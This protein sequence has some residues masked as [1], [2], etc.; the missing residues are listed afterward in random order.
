MS[1]GSNKLIWIIAFL[2]LPSISFSQNKE[3]KEK[4]VSN[5]IKQM[6]LEEKVG[7][8]WQI[9]G[10]FATGPGGENMGGLKAIA[11]GKVGS[12]LNVSGVNNVRKFQE[13]ALQSRLKIPLVFGMDV[14]HGFRTGFPIPLAEASSF[15]LEIIEQG[16]RWTATAAAAAGLNWTFA[17]MVDVS[18]DARWG[19]V[20]EGAGEDAFYGAGVAVAKVNGLQGDD[21][22]KDNTIMA[23]VKHFAGYGA[24]IAGKDYNNVDMSM[25]HFANFYMAPY[26]AAAEAGA[27]TFM[28]AFNDFDNIPSTANSFLLKKLLREKWGFKGFV[29]SDWGSVEELINHRV[30]E[31]KK[32]AAYK[33]LTAGLDMEMVSSCYNEN[34]VSLVNEK[35]ISIKEIDDAVR[36]ILNKKFELGLFEDPFR[37]CDDEREKKTVESPESREIARRLAERSIV[38]LKKDGKTL[39]FS[40]DVRN[41]ALIGPLA[42]SKQDMKGAWSNANTENIITLYDAMQQRGVT[43]NYA[44]GYDLEKNTIK[45]FD[46]TLSMVDKS[47]VIVIAMGERA[48]ESGEMRSKT[49]I[50]IPAA[51]QKLVSRLVK[52][53]KP[54]VVLMMSGRPVIFNQ[55]KKE[56]PNIL[57]TWWLGSEAGPAICNVLWGDY[58]PSGK[59]A[60][61]FP[62]NVGQIPIY[63]QYKSTGRPY[64]GDWSAKYID[65][66]VE[67][68][69]P[70]G[71]GL[72]YTDFEYSNIRLVPSHKKGV[73]AEVSVDIANIGKYDG[74]EVVQL[75]VR[76]EVASITRPIKQ[77][78][79]F[80]KITLKSGETTTITFDITAEQLGFYDNDLNYVI[81]KGAFTFMIGGDSRADLSTKFIL[82]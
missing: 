18:W 14:I 41:V 10:D 55:V 58:N 52:T 1:F 17:P 27:A 77:L 35:K 62:Q 23:C 31:D 25:G 71:F 70:F 72:S 11:E 36:R 5:L 74:E 33:S 16:A 12:V 2:F 78:K 15:D 76:D 50:S 6:T 59:L 64:P 28:S 79:G 66:P 7:Q 53:G 3:N 34:L 32:E 30:A 26:K 13:A 54:L 19:R 40:K 37:Y 8:L 81:E 39:P 57:E 51:Q 63:Y 47:D 80:K 73:Y 4:F 69:Y 45:D 56:A 75:Y 48:W 43:V 44:E 60:M 61:T 49:D 9:S 22:S 21:L 67:P 68:A 65:A 38:L 82:K 29:V 24:P 42:K 46:A 20:L